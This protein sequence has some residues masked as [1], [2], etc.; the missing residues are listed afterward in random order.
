MLN[1][2]VFLQI[3]VIDVTAR[4]AAEDLILRTNEE[5]EQRVAERTAQLNKTLLDLKNEVNKRNAL[6]EEL[7]YKSEILDSTTSICYAW[8]EYA[9]CIYISPYTK[10]VFHLQDEKEFEDVIWNKG[11]IKYASGKTL[12]KNEILDIFQNN[13]ELDGEGVTVYY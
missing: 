7:K 13:M 10:D 2:E 3:T 12:L 6:D 1:D 5:L 9:E 4:R 11:Y 8:N